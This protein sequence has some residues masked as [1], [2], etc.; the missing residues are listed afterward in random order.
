MAVLMSQY[1]VSDFVDVEAA[2]AA[3]GEPEYRYVRIYVM[4][5][6]SKNKRDRYH[7]EQAPVEVTKEEFDA[8]FEE[9]RQNEL[10]R[11][12]QG[13]HQFRESFYRYEKVVKTP[14]WRQKLIELLRDSM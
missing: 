14:G 8:K 5:K 10:K 12:M 11:F 13:P 6:V 4:H 2:K 3:F 9:G 7:L 1:K